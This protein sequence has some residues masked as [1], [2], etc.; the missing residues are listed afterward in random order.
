MKTMLRFLRTP[1]L[2]VAFALAAVVAFELIAGSLATAPATAVAVV[3]LRRVFDNLDERADWATQIEQLRTRI[4]DEAKAKEE[5][6]AQLQS[7]LEAADPAT[8]ESIQ[9]Q[10]RQNLLEGR[11]WLDF[12]LKQLDREVAIRMQ[13]L[14][15]KLREAADAM[16]ETRGFDLVL[17]DDSVG[18]L[19]YD[20][21]S[22]EPAQL[23]IYQQ[24]IARRVLS[25]RDTIDISDDLITRMNNAYRAGTP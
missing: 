1:V 24:I 14:Y 10:I 19:R 2:A 4:Q 15:R 25:A 7:Q 23:Q 6:V 11:V 12:K 5:S 22:R 21:E 9:N 8:R 16:A 17:V 20:R 13:G 18:E 3:D